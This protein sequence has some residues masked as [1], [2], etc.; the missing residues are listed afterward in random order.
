MLLSIICALLC[1][2][3]RSQLELIKSSYWEVTGASAGNSELTRLYKNEVYEFTNNKIIVYN[4]RFPE[5]LYR[6]SYIKSKIDFPLVLTV[7]AHSKKE[8]DKATNYQ[9]LLF[10]SEKQLQLSY[11]TLLAGCSEDIREFH[12]EAI[13]VYLR[14]VKK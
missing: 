9:L 13:R 6:L 2:L 3:G 8:V 14:P 10:A 7:T 12:K 4:K 11:R 5:D 1:I